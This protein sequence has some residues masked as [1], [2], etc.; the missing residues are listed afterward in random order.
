MTARRKL[1]KKPMTRPKKNRR[2]RLRRQKAQRK[3][4]IALGLPKDQV[5]TMSAQ[6]VRERLKR[7]AAVKAGA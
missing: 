3:R 2:E 7:P 5:D 1:S 4:L 6:Q